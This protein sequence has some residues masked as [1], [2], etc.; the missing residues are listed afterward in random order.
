MIQSIKAVVLD[1]FKFKETSIICNVY[2]L[3]YGMMS[4]LISGLGKSK[5][6]SGQIYFQPLTIIEFTTHYKE[7]KGLLRASDIRLIFSPIGLIPDIRKM[8]ISFFIAEI[9]LKTCKEKEQDHELFQLLETTIK[10][11]EKENFYDIHLFF[12]VQYIHLLGFSLMDN[13]FIEEQAIR[14]GYDTKIKG[15]LDSLTSSETYFPLPVNKAERL[16]IIKF[17]LNFLEIN[18][19]LTKIKSL[20]VLEE[21]FI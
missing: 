6:I 4:I 14:Y 19:S 1:S 8:A 9:V 2:S 16:V 12:L 7:R 17:I 11:F 5:A 20:Q 15:I 18:V 10:L 3:D 13:E 21:I